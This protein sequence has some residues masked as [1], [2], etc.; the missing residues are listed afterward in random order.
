[1]GSSPLRM[2]SKLNSG[3]GC[4]LEEKRAVSVKPGIGPISH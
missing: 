1:M 4:Q 3:K 2:L